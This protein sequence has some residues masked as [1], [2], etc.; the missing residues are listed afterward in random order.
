MKQ[1]AKDRYELK[2]WLDEGKR[3]QSDGG[4]ECLM[5]ENFEYWIR[6][7]TD[8]VSVRMAFWDWTTWYIE[9]P[10][11]KRK[12][13]DRDEIIDFILKNEKELGTQIFL[14]MSNEESWWPWQRYSVLKNVKW[15]Y[16]LNGAWAKPQDFEVEE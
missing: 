13:T 9:V 15:T 5:D 6:N 12:L 2:K 14:R 16:R 1:F 3:P 11:K 7:I 4:A 10:G 8:R